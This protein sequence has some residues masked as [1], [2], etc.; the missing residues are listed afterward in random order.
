[1]ML[2]VKKKKI[3]RKDFKDESAVGGASDSR[4]L[5]LDYTSSIH[6]RWL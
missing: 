2:L 3:K 5:Y 4:Y 6:L 1:M